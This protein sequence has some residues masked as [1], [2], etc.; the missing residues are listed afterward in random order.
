MKCQVRLSTS[1]SDQL[2]I[3]QLILVRKIYDK[4]FNEANQTYIDSFGGIKY[5]T[6]LCLITSWVI[7]YL[8]MMKGIASSGKIVYFTGS[9][10]QRDY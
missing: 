4:T 3:A 8:I 1:G 9:Q 2:L 6:F 7:V 5:W 10:Y